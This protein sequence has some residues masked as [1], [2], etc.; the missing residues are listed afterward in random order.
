MLVSAGIGAA[1]VLDLVLT[2]VPPVPRRAK[3][4]LG[5]LLAAGASIGAYWGHDWRVTA[6]VALGA[7]G[8]AQLTHEVTAFLQAAK[9]RHRLEVASRVRAR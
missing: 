5:A 9:D 4:L 3:G 1:R 6:L 7:T 8:V 2:W